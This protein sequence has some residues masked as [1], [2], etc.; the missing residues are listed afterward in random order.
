M[1]HTC[2]MFK[3]IFMGMIFKYKIILW[4][5]YYMS[6][7]GQQQ[8]MMMRFSVHRTYICFELVLVCETTYTIII[9][10]AIDFL[11]VL[12]TLCRL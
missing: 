12:Y 8:G 9:M 3:A 10:G 5:D 7:G 2:I 1:H 11:Y 4:L 6:D